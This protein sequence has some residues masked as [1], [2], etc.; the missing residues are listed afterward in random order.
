MRR[1]RGVGFSTHW[2]YVGPL[3]FMWAALTGRDAV[4]WILGDNVLRN[5]YTAW[6]VGNGRIG[7]ADLRV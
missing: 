1:W 5:V 3:I 4:F 6:D 2:L 7:F